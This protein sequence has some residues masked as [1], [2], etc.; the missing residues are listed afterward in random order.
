MRIRILKSFKVIIPLLFFLPFFLGCGQSPEK[1]FETHMSKG[2]E[3]LKAS[4]FKEASIEF[5]NAVQTDKMNALGH[6]NLG[7]AY[8]GMGGAAGL[9]NAFRELAQATELRPDL[10]DAQLKMGELLVLSRDF[11]NARKKAED[12]L[13]KAP[14]NTDAR[15]LL[16]AALAGQKNFSR[17]LQVINEALKADP[18]NLKAH[19][20]AAG[21]HLANGDF[22]SAEGRLRQAI[23]LKPDSVDARLQLSNMY[24]F[25]GRIA[26]AEGEIKKA[27]EAQPKS[28]APLVALANLYMRTK[29]TELAEKT[30]MAMVELTPERPEPYMMLAKFHLSVGRPEEAIN[31]YK[32]GIEKITEGAALRKALA[33]LLLDTNNVK[34]ASEQIDGILGKNQNDPHGLYLRGRLRLKEKK[35]TEAAED[36]KQFVKAEPASPFGRYYLGLAHEA[37]GNPES[38]RS[39]FSEAIKLFPGFDGARLALAAHL[40]ALGDLKLAMEETA[41]VLEKNRRNPAANLIA[42]DISLRLRKPRE[43]KGFFD[44]IVRVAPKDPRGYSRLAL[45]YQ[46]QGDWKRAVAELEKSLAIEPGQPEALALIVSLEISRKEG[47][48]AIGRVIDYMG[49]YP[50]NPAYPLLLG[51]IHMLSRNLDEAEAAFKKAIE[52]KD[53][54]PQAYF[55]L[56]N[57][58]YG[59]GSFEEA[60]RRYNEAIRKDPR[61]SAPHMMLGVLYEKQGDSKEAEAHYKKVLEINP[62]F[63]PALNNLAWLYCE[64]NGNIDVALSLA[65]TAKGQRPEDP[66]VSDTLGWIYYKKKAYL[67]AVSLLRESLEKA[68]DN[69]QIRYHLG[70]A[71]LG[72]GDKRLARQELSR[73]LEINAK[74]PGADEARA[75]LKEMK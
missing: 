12:V 8:L 25:Q 49:K 51:R 71:Y 73:S 57:L 7:L 2:Q 45:V 11:V 48:K 65:E 35:A 63:A 1:K 38:A 31:V 20:A 58:Y 26:E 23:V 9:Q 22:K 69:P 70:M 56:G 17:A 21:I 14:G 19:M 34:D 39:E 75:A 36:L 27:A 41:K 5:K 37:T 50:D 62:R 55:D 59:R 6:Y 29:R 16:A 52:I 64:N 66:Y 28:P 43:A 13:V 32:A 18:E 68:P 60:I 67:K 53:D 24:V 40:M 44:N 33:E 4:N 42:G 3:Y 30:L 10:V 61:Q 46:M 74:Y 15:V 47:K 72:K 54:I